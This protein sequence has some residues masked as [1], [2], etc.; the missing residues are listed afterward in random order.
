MKFDAKNVQ[1]DEKQKQHSYNKPGYNR[2]EEEQSS[3]LH[4][5]LVHVCEAA[6]VQIQHA[7]AA[8][9]RQEVRAAVQ[10][11]QVDQDRPEA[12]LHL[13]THKSTSVTLKE[14]DK[15]FVPCLPL[16]S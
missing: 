16:R 10:S 14:P 12:P 11:R 1:K 9:H 4:A 6:A 5:V 15:S 3:D 7:D 2:T 13:D 8:A